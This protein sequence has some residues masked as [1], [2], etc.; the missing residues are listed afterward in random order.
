MISRTVKIFKQ[1]RLAMQGR[2]M[3]KNGQNV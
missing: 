2:M 3:Q 1:L